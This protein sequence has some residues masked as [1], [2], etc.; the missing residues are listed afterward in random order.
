M[1]IYGKFVSPQLTT[2]ATLPVATKSIFGWQVDTF[3]QSVEDSFGDLFL[4][5]SNDDFRWEMIYWNQ[6]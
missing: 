5:I 2:R 6:L 3:T 1:D 4:R